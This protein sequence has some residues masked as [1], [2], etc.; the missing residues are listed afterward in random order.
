MT[1][2]NGPARYWVTRPTTEKAIARSLNLGLF[3]AKVRR[4]VSAAG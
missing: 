2:W 3:D 4:P 1:V